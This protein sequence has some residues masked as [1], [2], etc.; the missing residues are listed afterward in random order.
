MEK[1]FLHKVKEN[2]AVRTCVTQNSLQELK[3]IWDQ[4]NEEWVA[5]RIKQKGDNKCISLKNL[6]DIVLAHPD[7]KKRVDVFVLSIYNLVVFPK[8]LGHVDEV[9]TDLFDRL[10][11][12]VTPILAILAETFRSLNV[13]R[14]ASEGRFI[15]CAEL[16]LAWFHNHF[17]K[18][19]K[20]SYQGLA[21]CEFSYK[22][23]GYK[24]KIREMSNAWNQTRR[25]KRLAIGPMTTLEYNE[26][27]VRRINDNIPE[28]SYKNSQS[29]E[30][31]LRVVPS[32]LQI[33]K[34]DFERRNAEL[35]KKIE[36][37][38]EE[39][40]N[41][42]LDVD[43]QKLEAERLRKGKAKAEE[44]LDSLKTNYKKL[45]LSMELS[46]SFSKIEEMKERIE[47]LETT[48]QNC[49]IWIEYL[50]ANE[51]RQ[52]E[53]LHYFQNQVRNRGHIMGEVVV[54]IRGVAD[55]LQ[56][57]VVQADTL[58]V[59]YELESNRGQELASLLRK[60][61]VLSIRAKL[62]L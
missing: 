59:R 34:Q 12:G 11:K 1:G 51:D 58:S 5:A 56:T 49:G 4:W 45:H 21:E 62:Y 8:V 61:R 47:E 29:I 22:G 20:V 52:N 55:H 44:D 26:W 17:W 16:L 53:Q 10:D 41:L 60:I 24:K 31:N 6:N 36:Q 30:E 40:M 32:E 15:G 57:L 43:V 3:E 25:M 27:W 42:R 46:A 37:M 13:C 7:V 28:P 9:V 33:I 2:A 50:E 19:D 23:D 54:Q 18:V 14:R 38:E 39:K 35:K 48:L